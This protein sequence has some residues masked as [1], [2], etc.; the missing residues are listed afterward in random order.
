[1][2]HLKEEFEKIKEEINSGLTGDASKDVLYLID[3]VK[4][5]HDRNPN[6]E[7]MQEIVQYTAELTK[8]ITGSDSNGQKF[9]DSVFYKHSLA[10]FLGILK[11]AVDEAQNGNPEKALSTIEPSVKEMEAWLSRTKIYE[12]TSLTAY[13]NFDEHFEIALHRHLFKPSQKMQAPNYP[14]HDM[15]R[16]YG[17][18]LMDLQRF[19]DAEVALK[20]AMRWAPT[21][22]HIALEHAATFQARGKL[23]KFFQLTIETFKIAFNKKDI[24]RCFRNL[25]YYFIEKKLWTEAVCCYKMS[26]GCDGQVKSAYSELDFIN[27]TAGDC[28]KDTGYD[29]FCE[30]AKKYGFPTGG[31]NPAIFHLACEYGIQCFDEKDWNFAEYYLNIAYGIFEHPEVKK[32]LDVISEKKKEIN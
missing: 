1:M 21:K 26:L 19:D 18:I 16:I 27:K 11:I 5:F 31:G 17:G 3:M 13:Y 10:P 32:K 15:F 9:K 23:E 22:A 6:H 30:I 14:L 12:N 7:F 20:K 8:K 28:V 2:E 4:V 24:A 25:G 29:V